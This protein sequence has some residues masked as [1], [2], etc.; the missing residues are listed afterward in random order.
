M[1]EVFAWPWRKLG[2]VLDF[3]GSG[4]T[5]RGGKDSYRAEGTPLVRSMNVHDLTFNKDGLA[6][7]DDAQA[8]ELT[9]AAIEPD[10]VLLNITGA[11]VARCCLAPPSVVGGRVN[12]HVMILRF[13]RSQ[14]DPRFVERA[15][16]GPYK[17]KLLSIAGSGATR[18]ALTKADIEGFEIS[19]PPVPVQRI[20]GDALSAFDGLIENNRRRIEVLEKMARLLYR[21]WF[22]HFRFPGHEGV[23]LVDSELGPIPEGWDTTTLGEVVAVNPEAVRKS[24][25]LG[26]ILYVDISAVGPRT[27]DEPEAIDFSVAPG[28]A[29]RRVRHGDVI[30]STVRPNRRSHVMIQTPPENL[31]CST[32]FAVL[33][34]EFLPPSFVLELCS[35][36][37]FVGH[38]ESL[39]T[40]ATYP[41]VRPPDFE[42][43]AFALPPDELVSAWDDQV[44]PMNDLVANLRSQNRVLREARDLLLPRLVSGELDVSEL[45]LEGVLS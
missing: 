44:R 32:G 39:A 12:Q 33:R 6:F 2:N 8:A 24:D 40:G 11:S 36:D 29:R 41:A 35:T 37:A 45:D 20:V 14:A 43:Y 4:A 25:V 5:P 30:W 7:I 13:D 26:I 15:L 23:N 38:L 3:H 31:I 18:E 34:G 27:I 10:D 28:R 9:R 1:G 22:V 17:A 21:E 42:A 16:A 19:L